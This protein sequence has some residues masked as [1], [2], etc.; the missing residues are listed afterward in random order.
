[1]FVQHILNNF[2]FGVQHNKA[3][4]LES[5]IQ[6]RIFQKLNYCAENRENR[7]NSPRDVNFHQIGFHSIKHVFVIFEVFLEFVAKI[8]DIPKY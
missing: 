5:V 6:K 4:L 1:M 7:E 8:F 3:T 2:K